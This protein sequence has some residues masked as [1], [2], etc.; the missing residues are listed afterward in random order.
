[1]LPGRLGAVGCRLEGRVSV[2]GPVLVSLGGC[3]ILEAGQV[4]GALPPAGLNP[5]G[6]CRGGAAAGRSGQAPSLLSARPAGGPRR[7]AEAAGAV[8]GP[9][10]STGTN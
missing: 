4:P 10:P 6:A 3:S 2:P 5:S 8:I 1:M 9:G 7:N